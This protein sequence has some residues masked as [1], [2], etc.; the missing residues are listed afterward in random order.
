MDIHIRWMIRRDMP[1]VLAI[2][3]ASFPFPWLEDDFIRMLRLRN[4]IGMV[5]EHDDNIVGFMVYSLEKHRLD[6]WN[7]AVHP[8]FRRCGVGHQM[9][10][11][12]VAKLSH[13][14]RTR[15]STTVRESNLGAQ[16]F[17]RQ[18]GFQYQC[19]VHGMYDDTTEDAYVLNY[20]LQDAL[21]DN[22]CERLFS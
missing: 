19:T 18:M 7:F 1:E 9:V 10:E 16:L 13:Q 6:V 21:I 4:T 14:R 12:L 11:K 5:A 17:F 8:D 15:I 22:L 3:N 2:E 20:D